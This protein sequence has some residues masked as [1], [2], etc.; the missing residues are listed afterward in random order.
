M[1]N[2]IVPF[3]SADSQVQLGFYGGGLRHRPP[4]EEVKQRLR[5]ASS[6]SGYK[7]VYMDHGKPVIRFR[8]GY[9]S[10]PARG[11]YFH[12]L[13]DA[14][15]Y[16]EDYFLPM[17]D[18]DE[19]TDSTAPAT[20]PVAAAHERPRRHQVP[21]TARSARSPARRD[22]RSRFECGYCGR[23]CG[24]PGSLATHRRACLAR[25]DVEDSEAG[26]EPGIEAGEEPGIEAAEEPG[27][28]AAEEPGIEAAEEPGEAAP[29]AFGASPAPPERAR[30]EQRAPQAAPKTPDARWKHSLMLDSALELRRKRNREEVS[31]DELR[32]TLGDLKGCFFPE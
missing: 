2:A 31:E 4:S 24:N 18:D 17:L 9:I 19:R 1:A 8:H 29:P 26:E 25:N 27:I 21:R 16:F 5:S 12:G 28:E 7:Y 10:G 30:P 11:E 3:E 14:L 6:T 32:Q 15:C 13:D 23:E 22:S 20:P